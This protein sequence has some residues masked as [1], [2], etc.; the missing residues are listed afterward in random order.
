MDYRFIDEKEVWQTRVN[1]WNQGVR[2]EEAGSEMI[3]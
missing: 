1:N 2:R 3:K